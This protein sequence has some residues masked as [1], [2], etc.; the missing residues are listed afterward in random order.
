M[1]VVTRQAP[2]AIHRHVQR[3]AYRFLTGHLLLL[4]VF[5]SAHGQSPVRHPERQVSTAAELTAATSDAAPADIV[6]TQ[7]L[8]GLT[9]F[10]LPPG[11]TLRGAGLEVRLGFGPGQDGVQ[12]SSDNRLEDLVLHTD[13]DRRAVFNDAQVGRLGRLVLRNVRTVGAIRILVRDKVRSGHVEAENVDIVAADARA[14]GDRPKG[15]GVEVIPG[16]FVLWNQQADPG[17]TITADLTGLTAGRAGAPVRGSGI[18]VSGAGDTGGRLVVRRL[19]TGSVYGDGGIASGTPDRIAG[20]VFVVYGAFVDSVYN[21]GPVTTYGPNDMVLDNW[22]TVGRWTAD[23]KITSYGPSGIGF[24]NFGTVEALEV[25][26][27]IETFGQG[28]RGFNVYTGTVHQAGFERIV[29]HSDGAVGIQISQPVGD[30]TVRRGIET[31]GGTGDSLVKGVVVRLSAVALSIKP[32][33]SARRIAVAGG[34]ITHGAGINPLELHGTVGS[35]EVTDGFSAAG[36]G[37]EKL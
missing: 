27:P 29:T 37:F 5:A 32:G 6:V 11:K 15:Y 4:S 36:G 18:F 7:S 35:L 22:G 34:L 16:A 23:D 24:V 20:G 2:P 13:A 3:P 9:T 28:A 8:S 19:E 31:Y 21:R 17:V 1:R 14:F 25:K 26:A 10:R 30:I 12:L 33:G